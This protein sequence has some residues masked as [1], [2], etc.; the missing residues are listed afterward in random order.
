MKYSVWKSDGTVASQRLAEL[1][2]E[3]DASPGEVID[4]IDLLELLPDPEETPDVYAE[5]I[6]LSE[7]DDVTPPAWFLY[8]EQGNE[9]LQVWPA[10]VTPFDLDA[11]DSA[12]E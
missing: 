11:A 12:I 6:E 10:S 4:E 3:E 9:L 2:L 1:E 7:E 8:D 5:E